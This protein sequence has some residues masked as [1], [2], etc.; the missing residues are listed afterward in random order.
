MDFWMLDNQPT[1]FAFCRCS[2]CCCNTLIIA[3]CGDVPG[4]T[5]MV[6]GLATFARSVPVAKPPAVE[7]TYFA[8]KRA[9]IFRPAFMEIVFIFFQMNTVATWIVWRAFDWPGTAM[10]RLPSTKFCAVGRINCPTVTVDCC[11]FF[12]F[13]TMSCVPPFVPVISAVNGNFD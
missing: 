6:C 1:W 10:N 5:L 11:R 2:C 13:C 3:C 9:L 4:V 7:T 8:I 12:G